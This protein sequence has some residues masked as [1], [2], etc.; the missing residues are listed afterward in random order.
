VGRSP[1]TIFLDARAF[2]LLSPRAKRGV[3]RCLRASGSHGWA[4]APTEVRGRPPLVF[5]YHREEI[6]RFARKDR[7]GRGRRPERSEKGRRPE[8]SEGCLATARQ[9]KVGR[10]PRAIFLDARAFFYCHPE[11]KRGVPRRLCAS[12]RHAWA[13]APSVSRGVSFHVA[14]CVFRSII[15][16]QIANF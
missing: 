7:V 3:P 5:P 11:R 13:V 8:Q 4:V 10:S 6:S 14:N 15:L 1:R 2:F 16:K 9:D 12:G